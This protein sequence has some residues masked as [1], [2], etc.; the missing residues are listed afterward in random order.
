MAGTRRRTDFPP[1]HASRRSARNRDL[2]VS[3]EAF[4]QLAACN[5]IDDIKSIRE[6][7]EAVRHYAKTA[8]AGL[9]LQNRAAELKLRAERRAGELLR[10]LELRGGD[11][12]SERAGSRPTLAQLDLTK[13]QSARWQK[14]AAIPEEVFTKAIAFAR[15]EGVELTTAGLWRM[16]TA[17]T[18]RSGPPG[19]PPPHA[20]S[21]HTPQAGLNNDPPDKASGEEIIAELLNHWQL[22]NNMLGPLRDDGTEEQLHLSQSRHLRHVVHRSIRLLE[23]LRELAA[24]PPAGEAGSTR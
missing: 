9:E 6:K 21:S 4:Q 2:S 1:T 11:R 14:L 12:V 7:G 20:D 3:Q 19:T 8:K 15:A 5:S 22:L 13:S 16:A 18:R 10:A 23:T 17:R 24:Q